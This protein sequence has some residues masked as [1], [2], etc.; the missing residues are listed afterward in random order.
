[1][2]ISFPSPLFS[3]SLK[4]I[5]RL[6]VSDGKQRVFFSFF[7]HL[8]LNLHQNHVWNIYTV[9]TSFISRCYK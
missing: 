1:M 5:L 9:S 4:P 8:I 6:S 3:L 2:G 7:T